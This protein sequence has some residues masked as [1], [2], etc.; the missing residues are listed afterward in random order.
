MTDIEQRRAAFG[1]RLRALRAQAGYLTGK[2]FAR[3]IGWTPSK[4]SRI[5][6]GK[7]AVS[8]SDVISWCTATNAPESLASDLLNEHREILIEAA[9]FR[10]QLSKAGTRRQQEVLSAEHAV[11]QI[12]AFEFALLPGL[13]QTP[14]YARRVMLAHARLNG[15]SIDIDQ[16]VRVRMER[17]HILY[18]NKRSIELLIAESALRFSVCPPDV[19]VAQLDRLLAVSELPAVR[20]GIIP[21]DRQM[22]IIPMHGFWILGDQSV[23]VETID[24][25]ITADD[26]KDVDLYHRVM[27]ELWTVAVEGDEVRELLL[28]VLRQFAANTE[29]RNGD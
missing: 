15:A 2:A 27:D 22:P 16:A 10:R 7:Q 8:D 25:E 12:R 20:V 17:Q 3:H 23:V 29:N 11:Q 13:V 4:V 19:M 14:E 5:E 28:R 9:S 24:S 21:Q 6:T 1:E 18:D 26:P